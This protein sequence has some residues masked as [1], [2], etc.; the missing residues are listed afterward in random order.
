MPSLPPNH[1]HTRRQRLPASVRPPIL[2]QQ[3]ADYV[4]RQLDAAARAKGYDNI[5]SACSYVSSTIPAFA[6]DAMEFIALRDAAWSTCY[7]I[8]ADVEAGN[9]P[10]PTI[11]EV[12]SELP[13]IL[14]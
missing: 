7:A 5:L 14:H 6:E 12:I 3:V 1:P 2:I 11:Q 8:L 13:A 9:R 10:M 4:Q